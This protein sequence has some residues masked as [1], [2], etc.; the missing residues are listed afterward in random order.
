LF[1]LYHSLLAEIYSRLQQTTKA[2]HH[3][4]TAIKLT[5]SESEKKILRDKLSAALL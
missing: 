4:E 3:F 1:Y 2:V 5:Q